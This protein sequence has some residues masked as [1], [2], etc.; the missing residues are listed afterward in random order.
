[1]PALFAGQSAS[2]LL[3]GSPN[4]LTLKARASDGERKERVRPRRTDLV[5][6]PLW[7]RQ[8]VAALG[9]RWAAFP[10]EREGLRGEIL[11]VALHHGIASRFT[12]FV[13]VHKGITVEGE[14]V[15]VVQP[16]EL[17][18]GWDPAFLGM[19]LHPAQ[20]A[21]VAGIAYSLAAPESAV[22]L[23]RDL[24]ASLAT[25]MRRERQERIMKGRSDSG[26]GAPTDP[27]DELALRQDANGSYGG[28][29]GRTAAALSA[30]VL[31]GS[32]R[33]SGLRRQ[34]VRKA[35]DWLKKQSGDLAGRV[36]EMIAA[37]ESG[38]DKQ[39][40]LVE[41]EDL[42]SQLADKKA[43][44]KVLERVIEQVRSDL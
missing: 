39:Q 26:E 35:C 29:I 1:M 43:E 37:A 4:S 23:A 36:L 18:V 19:P 10:S 31:L 41:F 40:L 11:R 17:P 6:A 15:Q 25:P 30:L 28:D 9:D 32:T 42:L 44:G 14:P 13:A 34:A 22:S 21:P 38:V 33:K 3:A 7:A 20:A 27:A 24:A 2:I 8:R 16:V 12:A 5:L